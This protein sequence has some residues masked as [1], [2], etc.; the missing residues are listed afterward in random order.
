MI[1]LSVIPLTMVGLRMIDLNRLGLQAAILELHIN[2]A[3]SLAEKID[4]YIENLNSKVILVIRSLE[5]REITWSERQTVLQSLLDA[6][7]D[8]INISVVDDKGAELLKVYNPDLEKEPSLINRKDEPLFQEVQKERQ[9][10]ISSLCYRDN[11]VCLDIAYPFGKEYYLFASFCLDKLKQKILDTHIGRTGYAYLVDREGKILV[12]PE[13]EKVFLSAANLD[14]VKEV[15]TRQLLGSKEFVDEKGR[16]IIGA[17]SPVKRL[18]WGIII[19]QPK[20]EAYYS[21]TQMRQQARIWVVV[22]VFVAALVAFLL[23]R[24][25][26]RPVIALIKSARSVAQGDFT[27]EVQVRTH[28]ELYELVDTFNFMTARLKE[29]ADMQVEKIIA[30]KTKTEA[31]IFSMGDGLILTDHT[32]KIELVNRQAASLFRIGEG[33]WEEK[34]IWDCL[35]PSISDEIID[36]ISQSEKT[37]FKEIVFPLSDEQKQYFQVSGRLIYTPKG[38]ELGL[39]TVFHDV[40]L[41]KEIDQMK[42]DF[43]H[44]IT[45]DLRNPLASVRGLLKLLMDGGP[46]PLTEKQKKMLTTMDHASA[47]LLSLINDILDVAK[48]ETGKMVINLADCNMKQIVERVIE[49]Q[50][51]LAVRK[52]INIE[53]ACPQELL[54]F[55]ADPGL[56]ERLVTNLIGNAIKFTPE[57]GK[58]NVKIEDLPE[59]ILVEVAD[60]G[61]GIPPEYLNRVFDKFQQLDTTKGGTGLGLTISKYIVEG[62]LGK[63]WAESKVGEGAKFSF[64]IP[65]NLA[66]NEKGEVVCLQNV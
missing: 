4:D 60:T 55:S 42:D 26:T 31:V 52:N 53:F 9:T 19:Q 61:P 30:E 50:Q 45:H 54:S 37:F 62:H 7:P 46:G 41:E 13:K 15:L 40:T 12:H 11:L 36:L 56:L 34:M 63:I 51:P 24:N 38:E 3:S 16:E 43:V 22:F 21:V 6:N 49:I 5:M 10:Q 57:Y 25:L 65:K 14:I 1:L 27:T 66:K 64:W 20:E 33:K 28:D 18:G 32:G 44:S 2:L 59:R 8:I 58:V 29:Y 39:L 35:H 17:Y 48:I 47:R 23:A